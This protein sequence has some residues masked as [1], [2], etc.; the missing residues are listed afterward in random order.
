[1]LESSLIMVNRANSVPLFQQ[2]CQQIR[3]QIASGSLRP[4]NKLPSVYSL[5]KSIGVSPMTVHHAYNVLAGES[6]VSSQHGSGSYILGGSGR[7]EKKSPC[8]E[9]ICDIGVL[10]KNFEINQE[11]SLFLLDGI[12]RMAREHGFSVHVLS[13]EGKIIDNAFA[14]WL[15]NVIHSPVPM[16]FVVGGS[17]CSENISYLC[18]QSRPFV[19][20][21]VDYR[22]DEKTHSILLDDRG[23]TNIM[24]KR[25]VDLNITRIAYLLGPVGDRQGLVVRRAQRMLGAA[26]ESVSA[27]GT[28]LPPEYIMNCEY[29]EKEAASC[30]TPLLRKHNRPKALIVNGDILTRGALAAAGAEGLRVPQDLQ[31]LNY[32]DTTNSPCVCLAK[33]LV[34]LGQR[35]MSALADLIAGEEVPER[36]VLEIDSMSL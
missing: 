12:Y 15:H 28:H 27:L 25:L 33:P 5:A 9:K 32:A 18:R 20:V 3:Q 19:L 26:L 14:P 23:A 30:L 13:T 34:S 21:D 11:F 36:A 4:G 10:I 22:G 7:S 1:M 29:D 6:L 8:R 2:I 17:L 31:I 24:I 35:A 16:G